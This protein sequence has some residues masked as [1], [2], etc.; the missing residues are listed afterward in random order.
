MGNGTDRPYPVRMRNG[1]V[2]MAAV[3]LAASVGALTACATQ[4]AGH[5]QPAADAPTASGPGPSSDPSGSSGSAPNIPL[6][7][8]GGG[9]PNPEIPDSPCDVL[10][11]AKLAQQ[12]GANPNIERKLDS[13]KVS[14]QEGDF[15]SLNTYSSLTLNFE[16][17]SE[18]GGR[19]LTV[20]GLPAYLVQN[21]HYMIISR[22][23]NPDAPGIMTCYIGFAYSGQ[24]AGLQIATQMLETVMPHYQY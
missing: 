5:G 22:S 12:F 18:P 17:K 1:R 7:S 11:K 10:D 16:K 24:L 19:N 21:D 9:E 15:V 8:N 20:A 23:K 6:P 3:L 14:S 13:C 4:I 2:R